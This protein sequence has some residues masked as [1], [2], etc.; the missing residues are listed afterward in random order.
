MAPRLR[1]VE[2]RVRVPVRS[3]KTSEDHQPGRGMTVQDLAREAL[4]L[5]DKL[6]AEGN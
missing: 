2:I 1:Y 5:R 3:G 6:A 4:K